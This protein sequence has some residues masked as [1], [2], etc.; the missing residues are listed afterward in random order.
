[1]G[2]GHPLSAYAREHLIAGL[3]AQPSALIVLAFHDETPAGIAICF[4][5]FSTFAA[6]PLINIHDLSV[7][8]AYRGQGLSRLLLDFVA[9]TARARGCCKLTLEVLENN[10]RAKGVYEAAGFRSPTYAE[11]TG[12]ALFLTKQLLPS[13]PSE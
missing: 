10:H 1:M 4:G 7:L 8:P 11:G 9:E 5:G 13:P 6:R 12:R 2:D 3:R